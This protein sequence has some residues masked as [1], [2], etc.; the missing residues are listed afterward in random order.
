ML[1]ARIRVGPTPVT[2]IERLR[3]LLYIGFVVALVIFVTDLRSFHEEDRR[4]KS[5]K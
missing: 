2:I 3:I 5:E 4:V 1:V